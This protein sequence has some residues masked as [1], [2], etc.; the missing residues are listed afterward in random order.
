MCRAEGGSWAGALSLVG[1]GNALAPEPHVILATALRDVPPVTRP[2]VVLGL[3]CPE[4]AAALV[5]CELVVGVGLGP[6]GGLCPAGP[7]TLVLCP[8]HEC[9]R[10]GQGHRV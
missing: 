7:G 3:L 2:Y 8:L 5:L 9:L 10:P 6:G 4:Q 1:V